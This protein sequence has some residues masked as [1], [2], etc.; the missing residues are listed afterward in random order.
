MKKFLEP[1]QIV[2]K[3]GIPQWV[4]VEI[5]SHHDDWSPLFKFVIINFVMATNFCYGAVNV[6]NKDMN[7]IKEQFNF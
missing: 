2:I 4:N 3:V 7:Q 1:A 6:Q 5:S